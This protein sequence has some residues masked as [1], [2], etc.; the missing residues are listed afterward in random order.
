MQRA[1][2]RRET[3]RSVNTKRRLGHPT[4]TKM[5]TTTAVA[6]V[7]AVERLER[8]DRRSQLHSANTKTTT[9]DETTRPVDDDASDGAVD[10]DGTMS[11][12][13]LRVAT[14]SAGEDTTSA[15]VLI[16]RWPGGCSAH[17]A[18][19]CPSSSSSAR[20][21]LRCVASRGVHRRHPPPPSTATVAA[22]RAA[23]AATARC[24]A[25]R[26]RNAAQRTQARLLRGNISTVSHFNIRAPALVAALSVDPDSRRFTTL[27][28]AP[29]R[30]T[31]RPAARL[32]VATKI[33]SKLGA[34]EIRERVACRPLDCERKN[35]RALVLCLLYVFRQI[36]IQHIMRR[37]ANRRCRLNMSKVL[38]LDCT[39]PNCPHISDCSLASDLHDVAFT[40]TT[41]TTRD[42]NLITRSRQHEANKRGASAAG[43][44]V[45][46]WVGGLAIEG[47]RTSDATNCRPDHTTTT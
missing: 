46:R 28:H 32:V 16:A 1:M 39:F 44:A 11:K 22:A 27:H 23:V 47:V 30:S 9:F 17:A 34:L 13:R 3:A 6:I 40:T 12:Q 15:P 5:T 45:G 7:A 19:S 26:P 8:L 29:R 24:R 2:K 18:R 41:T 31:T 38:T 42:A 36:L 4:T 20:R 25:D 33:G 37:K 21:A 10:N 14:T 35:A 43:A